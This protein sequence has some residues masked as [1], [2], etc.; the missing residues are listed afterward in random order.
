MA[1]ASVKNAMI[2]T[3][4]FHAMFI[5]SPHMGGLIAP[6]NANVG[7]Y[8]RIFMVYGIIAVSLSMHIWKSVKAQKE[9]GSLATLAR[10]DAAQ[11]LKDVFA[12]KEKPEE[13]E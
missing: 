8:T 4:L 1:N 3:I 13:S 2:G 11:M 7:E 10:E 6:N 5:V 12:L 9:K